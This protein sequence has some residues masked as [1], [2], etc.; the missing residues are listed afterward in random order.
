MTTGIYL[1]RFDSK[2]YYQY[3]IGQSKNI[4]QRYIQHCNKL[5]SGTHTE[6]M[7]EAYTL[8]GY[9]PKLQILLE[10]HEDYLLPME[11]LY[12]QA[13]RNMFANNSSKVYLE[14]NT[15][16]LVADIPRYHQRCKYKKYLRDLVSNIPFKSSVLQQAR[17]VAGSSLLEHARLGVVSKVT[18]QPPQQSLEQAKLSIVPKVKVEPPQILLEPTPAYRDLP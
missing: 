1:L 6:A 9:L 12:A 8:H 14:L 16:P 10:C 2:S 18:V 7:Q 11:R 3:Y 4:E 15:M 17:L 5:L 13:H